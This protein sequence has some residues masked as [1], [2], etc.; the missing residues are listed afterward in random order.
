MIFAKETRIFSIKPCSQTVLS[1]RALR[2]W[3]FFVKTGVR[4]TDAL[5]GNENSPD[6]DNHWRRQ[7]F[8]LAP[9]QNALTALLMLVRCSSRARIWASPLSSQTAAQ[10]A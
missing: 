1:N 4:Q 3:A 5:H 9:C 6:G 10:V 8:R 7:E 2:Q